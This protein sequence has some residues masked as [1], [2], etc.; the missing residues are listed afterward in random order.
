MV[1]GGISGRYRTDLVI[2]QGN[3]TGV[4]YRDEIL[5]RHVQ[6]FMNA[7]PDVTLFSMIMPGPTLPE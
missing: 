7:H 3:L 1:W 5:M 6:P 2:V 4:R